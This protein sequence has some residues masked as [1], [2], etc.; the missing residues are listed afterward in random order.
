VKKAKALSKNEVETI[1]RPGQIV[2]GQ[3][4]VD[5]LVGQGGM[6]AVWAGT[7]EHTG[8]RVALKVI[9]LSLSTTREAQ[10]LFHSEALAASRVNH[11]NVVT[12]FDV[13]EHEGMACIVM[14][15][16]DGEPL[17][18]YLARK[19]FLSVD[20]AT[21]LLLPAMRGVAA[22]NAQGVIHRDLKPQNIFICVGPDGRV[23][24]TKV[25]DFGISVIVERV[26][27]P[28]A[29][30][31]PALA[32]G[33]PAYMSP[34]HIL[35]AAHVDERA[36]VYGFGVLLYEALTGQ[37]PFPGEPGPALFD[38]VLNKPAP[39]VT[40][41]RP[42][43]PPGLVRIIETAMAKDRDL[44][45][46]DLNLMASALEDELMP[47]TPAPRLLTPVAGVS[48]FASRDLLSG[49][50]APAAEAIPKKQPSGKHQETQI[51]F[52][53]AGK[54]ESKESGAQGN[55]NR[56]SKHG[57]EELADV[58]PEGRETVLLRR[59][60][61]KP[62][63][64]GPRSPSG[65]RRWRGPAG[66]GLGVAL[67]FLM[68][69]IAM[70]TVTQAETGAPARVANAAQ[71][72]SQPVAQPAVP[73]LASTATPAALAVPAPLAASLSPPAPSQGVAPEHSRPASR[74][75]ATPAPVTPSR[76]RLAMRETSN[77][78]PTRPQALR[79]AW[80]R[81][82]PARAPS[83][84]PGARAFAKSTAPR[85]GRLSEADF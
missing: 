18:S 64:S 16:L 30:P 40:L 8:K 42:D 54:V 48:S 81:N 67:G 69:W 31:V 53:L 24:T 13:I 43:L 77:Y 84:T 32:M 6:A 2:G 74:A 47:P 66:A 27:D 17:A 23:V 61:R 15:L 71:P 5:H 82:E 51:L 75:H 35:G 76:S 33:T 63:L 56:G 7:N 19:G 34:E 58:Q 44:R 41:F 78:L 38:R 36:D 70:R 49:P 29:G 12:V 22:A 39:S 45:Y 83:S 59:S 20:E 11:P 25:L 80:E 9:L 52:A 26:M 28:L 21:S 65:H 46:S 3:Y 37:M 10:N 85:A 50:L 62:L 60:S 55:T 68:V 72:A 57:P 79:E 73:A 14:E 4:R 1:L